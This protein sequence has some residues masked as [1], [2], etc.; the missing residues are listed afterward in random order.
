MVGYGRIAECHAVAAVFALQNGFGR[1]LRPLFVAPHL[2]PHEAVHRLGESLGQT[3]CQQF[4]HDGRIVVA[5]R[6][7]FFAQ[8]FQ[9]DTRRYGKTAQ[10]VAVGCEEVGQRTAAAV[11]GLVAEHGKPFFASF[12]VG[13]DQIVF[14]AAGRED[15]DDP[16]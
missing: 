8:F 3:I 11:A 16:L 14:V 1:E 6:T 2:A 7:E 9:S 12:G 15:A 5:R 10:P 13:D 4:G